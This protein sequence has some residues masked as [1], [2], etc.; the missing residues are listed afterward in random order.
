MTA[1]LD[2]QPLTLDPDGTTTIT[3]S[4]TPGA[5]PLVVTV[6]DGFDTD[7]TTTSIQVADPSDTT[8]PTVELL[9]PLD[10]PDWDAIEI[11]APLRRASP[12]N[13][14]LVICLRK[15]STKRC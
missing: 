9:N 8:P 6:T 7:T 1:T 4:T 12:T 11:S 14:V 5:H 10:H 13:T 3:A 2:G 15:I